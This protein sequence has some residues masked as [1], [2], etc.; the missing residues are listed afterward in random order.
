MF[1]RLPVPMMK[2]NDGFVLGNL[3]Q[4]NAPCLTFLPLG[5]KAIGH[6]L[7]WIRET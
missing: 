6:V 5:Q 2:Q 1:S 7:K 3:H 4:K